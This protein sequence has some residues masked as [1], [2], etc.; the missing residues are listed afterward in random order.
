MGKG[1]KRDKNT[2]RFVT[3]VS[4]MDKISKKKSV[5]NT[6]N[7]KKAMKDSPSGKQKKAKTEGIITDP[8]KVKKIM[9]NDKPFLIPVDKDGN[10][11]I[12]V[13]VVRFLQVTE[14][15]RKGR[16]RA[17]HIDQ[18]INANTI[19]KPDKNG[20]FKAED[21]ARWWANP[22]EFDIEGIDTKDANIFRT[23]NG[24]RKGSRAAQHKIAVQTIKEEDYEMIRQSLDN[25]FTIRELKTMVENGGL[26]I[27]VDESIQDPGVYYPG[28][29]LILVN[30]RMAGAGTTTHEAIHHLRRADSER[31]DIVSKTRIIPGGFTPENQNAE[32]SATTAETFIRLDPNKGRGYRSY[33]SKLKGN[34]EKNIDADRELFLGKDGKPLRGKRAVKA[35]EQEYDKSKIGNLQIF[36]TKQSAKNYLKNLKNK[37]ND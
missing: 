11:P 22:N 9:V 14:G 36:G 1:P 7:T 33:Y 34:P 25:A 3:K 26:T 21:I 15:D 6:P 13:L 35:L 16:E 19:I 4:L 30:T 32:E 31:K 29:N 2:G 24:S 8:L 10:V 20:N 37:E 27:R 28:R 17:P 18:T 5:A 12:D 23:L